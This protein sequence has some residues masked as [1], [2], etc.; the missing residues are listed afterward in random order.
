MI[1]INLIPK[2]RCPACQEL[3]PV[4]QFNIRN[5]SADKCTTY[6]RGCTS[7]RYKEP[8]RLRAEKK[9]RD[10]GIQPAPPVMTQDERR[11]KWREK[12]RRYSEWRKQYKAD[13]KD[14]TN[15]CQ[16]A[17]YHKDVERNREYFKLSAAKRRVR[18]KPSPG[19]VTVDGLRQRM[20]VLGNKCWYCGGPF[21]HVDHLK[22][23]SRGGPHTLAN[24]RPACQPCNNSKHAQDHRIWVEKHLNQ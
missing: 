22:P 10:A 13:N 17:R 15:E 3:L 12:N 24:L 18:I 11:A 6:C 2:K 20:A 1:L 5:L 21:D 16:R 8:A 19:A 7:T 23:L 14:R 4:G 9:R